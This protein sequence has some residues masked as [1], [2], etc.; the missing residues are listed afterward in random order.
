MPSKLSSIKKKSAVLQY[1][2]IEKTNISSMKIPVRTSPEYP[3]YIRYNVSGWNP[4]E[5]EQKNRSSLLEKAI[6]AYCYVYYSNKK[7]KS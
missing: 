3:F 6:N 2:C 7:F 1:K 4:V 5:I